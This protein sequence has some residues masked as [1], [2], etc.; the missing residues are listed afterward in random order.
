MIIYSLGLFVI[1]GLQCV[2]LYVLRL[3]VGVPLK[4]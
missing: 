3:F 2:I 4:L 1:F